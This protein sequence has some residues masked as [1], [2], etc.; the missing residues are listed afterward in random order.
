LA[1][2]EGDGLGWRLRFGVGEVVGEFLGGLFI[3]QFEF[4]FAFLRAQDDRLAFHSPHHVEGRPRFPAQGHLQ[5]II[6]DPRFEGLAQVGL[7]FEETIRRAQP[8][9]ALMRP[10]VIVI[11]DPDL[12]ALARIFERVKLRPFEKLLPDRGPEPFDFPQGHGV[13][14]PALDM[15]DAILAQ[16][17]FE[18]GGAPPTRVLSP[19][20]GEHFLGRLK[21][22]RPDAIHLDDRLRRGAAKQIGRRDEPRVIIQEGDEI[23]IF[24]AQP[25][26]EDIRLPHLIGRRPLEEPRPGHIAWAAWPGFLQQAGTVKFPAHRFRASLHQEEPAHPLGDALDPE[27]RVLLFELQDRLGDGRQQLRPSRPPVPGTVFQ[28]AFAQGAIDPDPP[29]ERLLTDAEFLGN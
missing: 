17:G 24:A 2:A 7:D 10:F 3:G 29:G 25:E 28:S 8:A 15:G 12:N 13:M 26:G 19:I 18:A 1:C 6:F 5:E 11:F 27:R 23:R 14:R 16:L 9:D 21:L 22:A 4:E 20:V